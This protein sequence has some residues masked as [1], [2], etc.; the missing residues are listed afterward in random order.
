MTTADSAHAAAP[1]AQRLR[2]FLSEL[3]SAD[4]S[5]TGAVACREACTSLGFSKAMFSWVR[6]ASWAPKYV[7]VGE[8]IRD[9]FDELLSAVDGT[10]VPL[11]R[12]P[13]E[14][15]LIRHRRPYVLGRNAYHREAYRPLIDLSDPAAYAA[16]PIVAD[17]RTVATLHVDRNRDEITDEDVRLLLLAARI[18]GTVIAARNNRRRVRRVGQELAALVDDI[19]HPTL[20]SRPQT[21]FAEET[22]PG[23]RADEHTRGST[24]E[25]TE[26][27]DEVLRL[28]A[29]GAS[30][31]QIADR[32]FISDGTVKCHVRR[33]F[34][35]IGVSSRAQAAAFHREVRTATA[36]R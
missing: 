12:A 23:S 26:R 5:A 18:S 4:E 10:A 36:A 6:D 14:A 15:D 19:V 34:R 28:L 7:H 22:H 21:Y 1:S 9:E 24:V 33:I 8:G 11:L 32:L 20:A 35:K 17:G 25:L 29:T 3:Q 13:R 31:Q 30:N 27:E 2:R 16:A